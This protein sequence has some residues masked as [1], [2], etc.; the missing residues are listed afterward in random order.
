MS[1]DNIIRYAYYGLVVVLAIIGFVLILKGGSDNPNVNFALY[2][3]IIL[4]A[5]GA[6][7]ALV[8]AI[9]G[10]ATRFKDNIKNIIGFVVL[11]IAFFI[12]KA[13]SSGEVPIE[14]ADKGITSGVLSASEAG[15]WISL[16]LIGV[17]IILTIVS[18]VR[19]LFE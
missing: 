13:M 19:N 5:I 10:L 8:F 12:F 6:G 4:V 16:F 2:Q 18:G 9:V 3:G 15:I 17:A 14:M 11:I 1:K 7:L